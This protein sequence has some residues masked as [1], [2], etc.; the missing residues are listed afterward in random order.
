MKT[1]EDYLRYEAAARTLAE[2]AETPEERDYL[3]GRAELHRARADGV[4]AG[5]PC[6]RC[7]ARTDL[8]GKSRT[9][10][11]RN[12]H[13]FT[14]DGQLGD[15]RARDAEIGPHSHPPAELDAPAWDLDRLRAH[16]TSMHGLTLACT[17]LQ[18]LAA[19]H[20]GEHP[21]QWA[22]QLAPVS[23]RWPLPP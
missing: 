7:G 16:M 1:R 18:A 22:A 9:P 13:Q 5:P 12:C 14:K 3:L 23:T 17:D 15:C 8:R 6:P 4:A 20:A 21:E 11:C 2:A 10:Y 19:I